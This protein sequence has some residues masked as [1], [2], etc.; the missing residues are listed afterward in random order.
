MKT[1][2]VQV[3]LLLLFVILT[4]SN[5]YGVSSSLHS[6]HANRAFSDILASSMCSGT[7]SS[8][9]DPSP[10]QVIYSHDESG[11]IVDYYI[12]ICA[13]A[14]GVYSPCQGG[15]VVQ[16]DRDPAQKA[17][18]EIGA[19]N[20]VFSIDGKTQVTLTYPPSESSGIQTVIHFVCDSAGKGLQTPTQ[21]PTYNALW[22]AYVF[23]QWLTPYACDA[24][25]P[26]SGGGGGSGSGSDGLSWGWIVIIIVLVLTPIYIVVGC[27]I[28]WRKNGLR[29]VEACPQKDCWVGYAGLVKEGCAFTC[30]GCQA[31]FNRCTRKG[32]QYESF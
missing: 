6:G 27:V 13:P 25:V 16:Q 22:K 26:S 2:N 5:A 17:C 20:G 32:P 8:F 24:K 29:G 12:S 18:T 28:N 30:L 3:I 11:Q 19:P 4:F 10:T 23:D 15:G 9:L 14:S 1:R 7:P 31:L 21:P